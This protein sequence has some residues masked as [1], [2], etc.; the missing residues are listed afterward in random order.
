MRTVRTVKI[1][2]KICGP[3]LKFKKALLVGQEARGARMFS[4]SAGFLPDEERF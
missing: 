4:V 1:I 3:F 2:C